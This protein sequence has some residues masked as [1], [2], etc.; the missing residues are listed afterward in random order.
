MKRVYIETSIPS[1]YLDDR[2]E[3]EIQARKIWTREWWNKQRS[4]YELVTS[5]A[6]L[7]ELSQGDQKQSRKR[8]EWMKGLTILPMEP[9]VIEIVEVYIKRHVMPNDPTGDAMHLALASH[10]KCDILLTWNC[11][12]LANYN[13]FDHMRKVNTILGLHVPMLITPLELLGA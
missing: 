9:E 3:P 8:I 11:K 2:A 7:D 10:H 1:A 4:K 5:L 13:K 12:H 6:V